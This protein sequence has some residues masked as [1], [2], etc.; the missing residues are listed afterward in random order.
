MPIVDRDDPGLTCP[1]VSSAMSGRTRQA[2]RPVREVRR[3]SCGVHRPQG[4][5]SLAPSAPAAILGPRKGGVVHSLDAQFTS[6]AWTDRLMRV[7]TRISM[8]G[9]GRSLDNIFIER[10]WRSL[11]YER[12]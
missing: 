4:S 5:T 2:L 11:K 9:K 10:L 6:V 8:D 3:R 7:G 1:M 12:V